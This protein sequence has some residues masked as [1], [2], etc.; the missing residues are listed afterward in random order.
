[1]IT[2][3]SRMVVNKVKFFFSLINKFVV[4]NAFRVTVSNFE[5]TIESNRAN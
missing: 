1:M 2:P 5:Y 3:Y 4:L